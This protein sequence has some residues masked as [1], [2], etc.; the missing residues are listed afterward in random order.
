M[1]IWKKQKF[2][3]PEQITQNINYKLKKLIQ[4]EV[5]GKN[6][7]NKLHRIHR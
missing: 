7:K 4:E 5:L 2:G 3:R 1:F 6:M